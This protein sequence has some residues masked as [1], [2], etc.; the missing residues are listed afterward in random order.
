MS[1]R[2]DIHSAFE[3]IAPPLGGMPERVV[4]TVLADK[5]RR[6]NEKMLV[7]LRAPLSLV[8]ALVVIAVVA[9][10]LVGGRLAQDWNLF[11]NS[12]PAGSGGTHVSLAA[13]ESRPL[14]LPQVAADAQCPAGPV[15][16]T[17]V[18][19]NGPFYG[20]P[21]LA[22]GP[23]QTAWGIYW[24]LIGETDRNISGLLLIRAVD[25]KTQQ[26][27]VFVGQYAAGAVAGTDQL[28]GATVTQRAELVLDA[29]HQPNRQR[30]GLTE[31]P[32]VIGVPNGNSGC[33][34]YQIDG[35]SF[36]ET[37]VFDVNA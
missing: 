7:R 19:G 32:F 20:D 26:K 2:R 29:A 31:W 11:H 13:L 6:R 36:T 21:G 8:A 15:S 3:T 4:Q 22:S 12:S 33:Y 24:N 30:G 17:G 28:S 1:L 37:F 27:Y 23:R 9:A 34:G 10:V 16:S 5:R 18:F 35:D 25:V 14:Q